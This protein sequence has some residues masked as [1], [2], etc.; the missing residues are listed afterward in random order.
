MLVR[1]GRKWFFREMDF[2]WDEV[3]PSRRD[4]LTPGLYLQYVN[5]VLGKLLGR[6]L[7]DETFGRVTA[8]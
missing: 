3:K 1:Q 6:S 2:Q 5:T 7:S 8:R 4:L